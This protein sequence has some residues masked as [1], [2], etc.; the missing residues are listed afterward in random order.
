MSSL[1][2]VAVKKLEQYLM[3]ISLCVKLLS[4]D[5]FWWRANDHCNSVGNLLLHLNGNVRQWIGTGL[6]A[7]PYDRDR[8]AEFA[9]R[10]PLA[11]EELLARLSETVGQACNIIGDLPA[12]S[13]SGVYSIQQRE[14]TGLV[15]IFHVVEHFAFHTG[16][17]IQ[18]TKEMLDV[19]LSFYDA[20]G[21]RRTP[22]TYP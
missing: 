20:Q 18:V 17:I 9:E 8:P 2:N 21:R 19:D 16:Q 3:Q 7:V 22:N 13:L 12:D 4:N 15:A 14:V 5:Q 10:R 6:G 1:Q 11:G